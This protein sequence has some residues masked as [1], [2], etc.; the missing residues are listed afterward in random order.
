[1]PG[2]LAEALRTRARQNHRSLQGELMDIL[3][4]AVRP[5]TFQAS[6]LWQRVQ[7]LQ[8]R[9]PAESV[10]VLRKDRRR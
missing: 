2:D 9:T 4:N 5:R 6:A 7:A 1:M 10:R 3:E 8:L